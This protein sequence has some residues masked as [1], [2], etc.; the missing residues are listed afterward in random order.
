MLPLAILAGGFGKRISKISGNLPKSLVQ[1]LGRPFIA[2]QLELF[3]AK[4]V[5]EVV[6][7]LSHKG[8]V[9]EQYLTSQSFF[10]LNMKFSYDGE[11]QLGT[12]GAIINALEKLGDNFMVAYGDSYLP[13]D[14]NTIEGIFFSQHK[15]ALMA[16]RQN[17]NGHEKSNVLFENGN[18]IRYSKGSYR[19]DMKYIDYGLSIFN[20]S[21][22]NER[23]LVHNLDLSSIQEELSR[24]N[25]VVGH[26][27]FE[28]YYEVGSESG[29]NEFT[30][31][32]EGIL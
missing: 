23:K 29:I 2:W 9:I 1:I 24:E 16:V 22:F 19:M 25:K 10:G 18:L 5:S 21:A 31:Y 11:S 13:T 28:K 4:G 20:V 3:K 17:T 6:L 8:E 32:L 14:I 27:V 30:A 7:C 26:E 12:G 15:P